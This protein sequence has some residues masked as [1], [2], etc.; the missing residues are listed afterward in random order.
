M[1]SKPHD[2]RTVAA[3]M[4]PALLLFATLPLTPIAS[5]S[6][7]GYGWSAAVTSAVSDETKGAPRAYLWIPGDCA[8]VRG[9]VLAQHNMLEEPVLEH[10][11]FRATLAELGFAEVWITP[12]LGP[13]AN[14]GDL[15]HVDLA[16]RLLADRS[17]YAELAT[18][19]VVPIGHSA[20][21]ESPYRFAAAR[22][23]RT[24]AA[25]SLKGTWPDLGRTGADAWNGNAFAGVPLLFV[26]G[27]YEW[28]DERAGKALDFRRRFPAVP[29]SMLADAGGGHFDCHEP[30]VEFLA[31]YIRAAARHRLPAA[32]GAPLRAIDATEEG[33]LV[34]RWRHDRPPRAAAAPVGSYT[35]DVRETFWCFDADHARATARMQAAY[36]GRKA[37]LTGYVQDG[38]IVPQVN[39]THQQV[40]LEFRPDPAGDG[41][42]FKLTGAF[43]DTV[44]AGRP[45]RWTGLKAG[46]TID[47]ATAGGPVVLRR[48]CGPVTQL[49]TDTFALAFDRLG[50]DNAK[51]SAEIWLLAEHP[52]DATFKRAVQQSVLH[53][54]LRNTA[55]PAQTI[56]FPAIPD[57]PDGLTAPI[58]LRATSSAGPAARVRYYVRE[59]PAEI[60][61]DGVSLRLTRIPP[62]ARY[63]VDVT[64]VAWQW[65][66]S[67]APLLQSAA[68]VARTFRIVR[69]SNGR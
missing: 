19:P 15:A 28:A 8:R 12:P 57:Q 59:G 45:E 66:R 21:A 27:E 34:D 7:A 17:G 65:G 48:I 41:L 23:A 1:I 4:L 53:F 61:N 3:S 42:T 51:R 64:V 9:V 25:I 68:A 39:G 54:P 31:G 22:P 36:A 18:A 33:W 14:P 63:P 10:P 38:R 47:H 2:A 13:L 60:A 16:L 50:F 56:D 11:L 58:P 37:Q 67:I 69:E 26:S 6:T 35:G 40:T 29:F 30:L 20:L 44:P 32:D 62:R 49:A 24:L 55:G 43:L 52:G 5:A 46:S